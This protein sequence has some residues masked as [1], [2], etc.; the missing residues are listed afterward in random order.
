MFLAYLDGRITE[1]SLCA[2]GGNCR[3]GLN[4]DPMIKNSVISPFNF[5]LFN[6][7]QEEISDKQARMRET[8][9]DKEHEEESKEK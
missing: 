7:I 6:D 8:T 3:V 2:T 4:W 1:P 9:V 5:N